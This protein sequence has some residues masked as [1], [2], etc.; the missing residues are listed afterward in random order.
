MIFILG[1]I[2][3]GDQHLTT[4]SQFVTFT[5][6]PSCQTSTYLWTN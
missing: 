1:F 6:L 4:L 2:G 3:H 5:V